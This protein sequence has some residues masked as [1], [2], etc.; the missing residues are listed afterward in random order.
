MPRLKSTSLD[1]AII[2]KLRG[3]TPPILSVEGFVV[4][5]VSQ[6][7]QELGVSEAQAYGLKRIVAL[8]NLPARMADADC[9]DPE[10][11]GP[12]A[13]FESAAARYR[14]AMRQGGL[15]QMG[16]SSIDG[17][18]GGGLA[19]Q[20]VTEVVG[21]T[22]AGKTQLCM[23]A[24]A[25]A[26][27]SG[28]GVLYIDTTNGCSPRRLQEIAAARGG[29]AA[30]PAALSHITIER[31]YSLANVLAALDGLATRLVRTPIATAAAAAG[32][33]SSAHAIRLVI[34]D[35]AAAVLAPLLGGEGNA[36][37]AAALATLAAA[38]SHTA[39][40]LSV[41][42]LV[43]NGAVADRAPPPS[44]GGGGSGSRGFGRSGSSGGG[45]GG[46]KRAAL[47]AR[48]AAAPAVRLLLDGGAQSGRVAVLDKHPLRACGG[49]AAR[50]AVGGA[51]V[52]DEGA[53]WGTP[54]TPAAAL[55]PGS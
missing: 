40:S 49:A 25:V 8:Q 5:H 17:L 11:S 22:G 37:G 1:V 18:L 53:Q 12:L 26:A 23:S 30:A 28:I 42:V 10:T 50:F 45:D 20:Q 36:P 46:G 44:S 41:A 31:C 13:I 43:T 34:L 47:G 24:A 4:R 21:Q 14:Y 15:L 51:G 55:T 27:S 35:S 29:S 2:E 16:C 3:L 19:L 6:L 54:A 33:S 38:L 32:S 52:V 7:S 9:Q 48:W 39:L